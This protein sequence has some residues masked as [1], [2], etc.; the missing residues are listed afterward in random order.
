MIPILT[1]VHI[2]VYANLLAT[3]VVYDVISAAPSR[4]EA[5]TPSILGTSRVPSVITVTFCLWSGMLVSVC[6]WRLVEIFK[7]HVAFC[8]RHRWPEFGPERQAFAA[9]AR[10]QHSQ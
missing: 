10:G 6:E 1:L 8:H 2:G 5:G 3:T 4:L 9:A 7:N